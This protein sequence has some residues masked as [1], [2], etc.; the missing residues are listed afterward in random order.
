ME[1]KKAEIQKDP[2]E[3]KQPSKDSDPQTQTEYAKSRHSEMQKQNEK[4]KTEESEK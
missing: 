1:R 3:K 4:A 2:F